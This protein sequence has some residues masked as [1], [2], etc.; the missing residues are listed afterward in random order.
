[1]P[2]CAPFCTF[3]FYSCWVK[4]GRFKGMV[5]QRVVLDL[6]LWCYYSFGQHYPPPLTH[7][8]SRT[9]TP[10]PSST[11]HT[12]TTSHAHTHTHSLRRVC[13]CVCVCACILALPLFRRA[14]T[15]KDGLAPFCKDTFAG[16]C[17][18]RVW[19]RLPSGGKEAEPIID[20]KSTTAALEVCLAD[21]C[22]SREGT[23]GGG[24]DSL[25]RFKH[26]HMIH[27]RKCRPGNAGFE[28]T[29]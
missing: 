26:G 4:C 19:R 28:R 17:R 23:W 13:V 27:Q 11:T 16:T 24:G 20:A 6:D 7:A 21:G 15:L 2:L 18:L 29:K 1:M 9:F 3:V 22:A 8:H 25:R 10:P 14:P 5:I 12:H